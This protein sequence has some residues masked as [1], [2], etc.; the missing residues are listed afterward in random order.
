MVKT[1]LILGMASAITA[2][3]SV[4]SA[5]Q[6]EVKKDTWLATTSG[7]VGV[8]TTNPQ[9]KLQVAGPGWFTDSATGPTS[10]GI[11]IDKT[12][13]GGYG[14]LS[15]YD[16]TT[17]VAELG[18]SGVWDA[19]YLWN[20]GHY[21]LVVD[22]AGRLGI[23]TASPSNPLEMASGAYVSTTGV[24]TNASSKE[25]KQEIRP[26][27]EPLAV[28]EQIKVYRYKYRPEHGGDRRD[29]IGVIAEELPEEV[30]SADH[31]GAPT[32]ELVA[33]SLAA[34][35]ELFKKLT[36]QEAQIRRQEQRIGELEAKL[37]KKSR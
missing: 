20:N 30:A 18:H 19:F 24:W 8:G 9:T 7:N 26:L 5:Q 35:R 27:T 34:N 33:L 36:E 2:L 4:A 13:P 37:T 6:L 29:H 17:E 25:Y 11:R 1:G 3:G 16:G 10:G 14:R 22:S 28:L 15:I 23:G 21:N 32:A 12:G 31:K